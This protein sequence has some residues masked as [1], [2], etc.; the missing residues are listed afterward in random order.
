[1]TGLVGTVAPDG[2]AKAKNSIRV[3]VAARQQLV[4]ASYRALLESEAPRAGDALR[5]VG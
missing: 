2:A 4:R 5:S 1:M 3:L